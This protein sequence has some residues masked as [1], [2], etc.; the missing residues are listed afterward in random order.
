MRKLLNVIQHTNNNQ[1]Q[2]LIISLDTEKAF[3]RV[4]WPYLFTIMEKFGLG[5]GFIKFIW[6]IYFSPRASVL[7]NNIK[8]SELK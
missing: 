6:L 1:A 3:D 2:G 4:E 8:S 7:V 5:E